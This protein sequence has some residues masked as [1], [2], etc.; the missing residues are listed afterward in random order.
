MDRGMVASIV[1]KKFLESKNNVIS[2]WIVIF[3]T[4]FTDNYQS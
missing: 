3:Y 2:N 4:P 1:M